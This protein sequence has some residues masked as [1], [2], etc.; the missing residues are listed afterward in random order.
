M[1]NR[2]KRKLSRGIVPPTRVATD[3]GTSVHVR[4]AP[5]QVV[6]LRER[7]PRQ[8]RHTSSPQTHQGHR[9]QDPPS[10]G[11]SDSSSPAAVPQ[12]ARVA[13]AASPRS[14]SRAISASADAGSRRSSDQQNV[15]RA[16][17][18][19][20]AEIAAQAHGDTGRVPPRVSSERAA[21]ARPQVSAEMAA[22]VLA[23]LLKQRAVVGAQGLPRETD[24]DGKWFF[25]DQSFQIRGR[26][27]DLRVSGAN[28]HFKQVTT[29]TAELFIFDEAGQLLHVVSGR[30]SAD[31]RKLMWSNGREWIRED[32][33]LQDFRRENRAL[34]EEMRLLREENKLLRRAAAGQP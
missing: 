24:F 32:A 26:G 29:K 33:E 16:A 19:A 8:G 10:P 17:P 28:C 15:R 5:E 12:A 18:Q 21:E 27:T 30:L 7:A 11:R 14:R 34:C 22:E 6:S 2:W 1:C 23:R 25:G 31:L 4:T 20:A 13:A 9:P 3:S